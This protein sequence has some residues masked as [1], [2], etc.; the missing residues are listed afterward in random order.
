MRVLD[1]LI[2]IKVLSEYSNDTSIDNIDTINFGQYSKSEGN[3][4]EPIEWIVFD[5]QDDKALIM[6]KNIIDYQFFL[7]LKI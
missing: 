1:R 7:I 3:I 2:D 6:T 4:K 5:T